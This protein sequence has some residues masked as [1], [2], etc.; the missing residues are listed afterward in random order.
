MKRLLACLV[1]LGLGV[2]ACGPTECD[3]FHSL[4][5]AEDEE[6]PSNTEIEADE[7]GGKGWVGEGVKTRMPT[8]QRCCYAG[9][10]DYVAFLDDSSRIQTA[11]RLCMT[12]SGDAIPDTGSPI[13]CPKL[14]PGDHGPTDRFS[15]A[16]DDTDTRDVSIVRVD[17]P[18]QVDQ[19]VPSRY[20]CWYDGCS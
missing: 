15:W 17:G 6:C 20:V 4:T 5:V 13:F 10:F 14:V 12:I 9:E 16:A 7:G 19:V 1:A 2:G 3:A 8:Y 18:P 11:D